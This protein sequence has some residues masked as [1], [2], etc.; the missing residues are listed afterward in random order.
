VGGGAAG[1]WPRSRRMR[2]VDL[3]EEHMKHEAHGGARSQLSFAFAL[4]T[5]MGAL[6]QTPLPE[7][8]PVYLR[9]RGTGMATSMFG[10]YVRHREVLIYPFYEFYY[11][12]NAEYVPSEIN[13]AW[14][15]AEYMATYIAH[16][17]LLYV[18]YGI[19][20]WLMFEF[21]AAVISATQ[22]KAD[23]DT[24][25]P[26]TVDSVH[27][28]GLGDVEGQLRWRYFSETDFRPELFSYFE[29]VFPLQPD[30]QLIG[31][32]DWEF[33]LGAGV[34]KGFRFGTLTGRFAVEY[35]A[36]DNKVEPG[37]YALEYV[38][39]LSK[40]FRLFGMVEGSQDEV[41]LVAEI[42]IHFTEHVVWKINAGFGLSPK[43]TDVA[44]ETGMMFSLRFGGN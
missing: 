32:S 14:P 43:A 37:E 44:P 9:D 33:K 25:L 22:W 20:E 39:R 30:R 40:N 13:D 5:F 7:E 24:T 17:G 34:T 3:R 16:E 36:G 2:L 12:H 26:D 10:T 21:E 23:N 18:A 8:L 28:A 31:T 1:K 11:D 27:E 6:A 38:R 41:E 35:D 15:E 42:Q 4:S 19:T 29:T